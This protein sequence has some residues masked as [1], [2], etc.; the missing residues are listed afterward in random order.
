MKYFPQKMT[1]L[2]LILDW[3]HFTNHHKILSNIGFKVWML[4]T[5]HPGFIICN[6]ALPISLS[7][8]DTLYFWTEAKQ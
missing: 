3:S 8:S 4:V 5:N 7:S 6:I 1:N 2:V